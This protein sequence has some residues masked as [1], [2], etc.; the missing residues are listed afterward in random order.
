MRCLQRQIAAGLDVSG[1]RRAG[2]VLHGCRSAPVRTLLWL[3]L[4]AIAFGA[5]G[6]ATGPD[7]GSFEAAV[8]GATQRQVS[9]VA[10][11]GTAG[12]AFLLEFF[13]DT[14][15]PTTIIRFRM[16]AREP[17]RPGVYTVGSAEE[18]ADFTVLFLQMEGSQTTGSL[19]GVNGTIRI[20]ESTGSRLGGD[21]DFAAEGV[22]IVGDVLMP[23]AEIG[24]VGSFDAAAAE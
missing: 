2:L 20:E 15:E 23:E 22:L 24:V 8:G 6:D 14:P 11:F 9:G 10:E 21:F 16:P 3:W 7:T 4:A 19:A 18:G 12:D 13:S 1:P 17:P 5:C